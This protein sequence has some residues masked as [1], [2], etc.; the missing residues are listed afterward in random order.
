M[1]E[2]EKDVEALKQLGFTATTNIGGA[3]KVWLDE[4]SESLR[5]AHVVIL[6][7]N[8]DPGRRHAYNVAR[9]L[10]TEAASVRVL[11][12]PDLREKGDVSD[13]LA[14]GGTRDDLERLAMETPIY[15]PTSQPLVRYEPALSGWIEGE[16]E[17][18]SD[19]AHSLVAVLN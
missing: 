4:H 1:V 11:E 14:A 5:G 3:E 17:L 6:P 16:V 7:D 12:L 15:A 2:G 8:D 19:E 13:W 9:A 10:H 18:S